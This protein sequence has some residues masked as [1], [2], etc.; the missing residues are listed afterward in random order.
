[1]ILESGGRKLDTIAKKIV[2]ALFEEIKS[3]DVFGLISRKKPA[4]IVVLPDD[5]GLSGEVSIDFI[6]LDFKFDS[7]LDIQEIAT[8]ASY[9][10]SQFSPRI[11][12]EITYP[13]RPFRVVDLA[14]IYPEILE[15]VRHELEHTSQNLSDEESSP[16]NLDTLEDFIRY[17]TDSSEVQAFTAGLMSKAK[18]SRLP[19]SGIIDAKVDSVIADAEDAGLEEEEIEKLDSTLRGAYNSYAKS[20][21][22]RMK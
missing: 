22:R 6:Q 14:D 15:N 1:M 20:R 10:R 21:Y 16:D 13:D 5:I 19:L 2:A 11:E 9:V 4:Q 17:Y 7:R 18:S 8:N 12:V 3:P